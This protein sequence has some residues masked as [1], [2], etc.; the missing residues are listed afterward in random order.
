MGVAEPVVGVVGNWGEG[1]TCMYTPLSFYMYI[2]IYN[3]HM[4][5]HVHKAPFSDI[6]RKK[7]VAKSKK[8]RKEIYTFINC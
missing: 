8:Q 1:D 7:E 3:V 6:E 5:N 4:N 2:R